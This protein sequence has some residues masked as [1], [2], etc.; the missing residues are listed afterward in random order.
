M[1]IAREY[2]K[3]GVKFVG[4]MHGLFGTFKNMKQFRQQFR[5]SSWLNLPV[6]FVD[7]DANS[8]ARGGWD[9]ALNV[10]N[11]M[12]CSDQSLDEDVLNAHDLLRDIA[13]FLSAWYK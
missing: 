1:G 11:Y 5:K 6:V 3:I 2:A 13:E 10:Q 12:N 7:S 8:V 9:F 4:E